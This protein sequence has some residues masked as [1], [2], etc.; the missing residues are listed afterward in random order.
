MKEVMEYLGM[1]TDNRQAS[2]VKHKMSEII[3][4]VF[5]AMLGNANEYPE[6]E[7]FGKEHK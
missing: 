1:V 5:L 3:A 4:L 2:K 7:E 6:I